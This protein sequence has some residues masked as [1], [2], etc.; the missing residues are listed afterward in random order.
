MINMKAPGRR[1][2][3]PT[4]AATR[5]SSGGGNRTHSGEGLSVGAERASFQRPSGGEGI[6]VRV[7]IGEGGGCGGTTKGQGPRDASEG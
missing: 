3:I 6:R 2:G 5:A 7:R 4:V 1:M